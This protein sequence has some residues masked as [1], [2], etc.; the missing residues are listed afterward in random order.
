MAGE[1]VIADRFVLGDLIGQGGMG[2]VYRGRDRQTGLEVAIKLLREEL[3]TSPDQVRRFAREGEALRALNHPS[4]VKVLASVEEQGRHYI[5]MEYV[6]GG[7]LGSL[8]KAQAQLP[9]ERTLQIALDL[10]DA[11]TRAHRLK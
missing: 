5:I 4:I 10:A 11:L 1:Q 7:S 2:Y 9:L 8:L 3:G 6:T